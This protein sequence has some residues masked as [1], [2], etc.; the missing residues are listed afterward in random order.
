MVVYH[1]CLLVDLK[2]T[3]VHLSDTDSADVFIVINRTD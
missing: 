2:G 1:N 3:V